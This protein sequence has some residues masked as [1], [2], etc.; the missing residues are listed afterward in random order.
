MHSVTI[1]LRYEGTWVSN[2]PF[3]LWLA[4]ALSLKIVR[5]NL[6]NVVLRIT[7][8]DN[9]VPALRKAGTMLHVFSTS[10]ITG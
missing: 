6:C 5:V 7:T 4:C 2:A 8:D 10:S 1:Y 9:G 3:L